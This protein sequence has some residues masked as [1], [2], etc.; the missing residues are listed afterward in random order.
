MEAASSSFPKLGSLAS[1][2]KNDHQASPATFNDE[3]SFP[4]EPENV[5]V[6]QLKWKTLFHS[7]TILLAQPI[8]SSSPLPLNGVG[9]VKPHSPMAFQMPVA[10][11]MS[12]FSL[13]L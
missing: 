13:S 7:E 8:L 12:P 2:L 1:I 5:T 3:L 10:I 4:H 9:S 11:N 6:R